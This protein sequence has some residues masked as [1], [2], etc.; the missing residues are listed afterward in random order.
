M[1]KLLL[2]IDFGTSTNFVTKY[3]FSKKDAVPVAN[4]G[5]YG[6]T[7]IFD[8]NIY[9]QSEDNYVIG[10][11]KKQHSDPENF[12]E[13]VKRYI[14]DDKKR[15]RVPN[16]NNR[17]VSAQDIAEMV[18]K[19]IAKK[20]EEN[21]N[22][23]IDGVVITVPYSYGKKY[24]QR[25]Q[26][27]ATNAGLKVIRLIEEPVAAAISYGIFGDDIKEDK[28]EKIAVFDLGGGTFDITI[29]D[30]E[31]SDAQH[32][33]IE[34]LNTDGVENLGGKTVDEL[35][36]KKFM[37]HLKIDYSIFSK[38]KERIKFQSELNKTAKNTK[39]LL[40]ESDE[41]EIYENVSINGE[42]K[43]LELNVSV[44]GFNGWLKDNNI[45]GKIEDAL[46]RAVY[47]IDLEPEDIDRVVLAGGT[48][49]IPII[50]STVEA[51]FGRKSEAKKDLGELVGHGA[52]I[53]AGL[54]EDS[55]LKYT[56]I[57]K[58]SKNIGVA[59]GNK[60]KKIL[61]KN[62]KYGEESAL[63]GQKLMN[64]EASSLNV[65]FYEGDSAKIE[66]SEKIGV[67]KINGKEFSSEQIYI[68]L[69]REDKRDSKI[70]AFFYNKDKDRVF[71]GYLE[72]V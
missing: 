48:S 35:L 47:D 14:V 72:D 71:E 8:N 59:R 49:T 24:R 57:R 39:E 1:D 55:S 64:R 31:K 20:V 62:T 30:F 21:E 10:D 34:V 15:Y 65:T 58:T 23:K 50:K 68:S 60:F 52:G 63:M 13:D 46:E 16:L 51:F 7:N 3:D 5:G 41:E 29:F 54:S 36:S 45:L 53:L 67:V 40:S 37:D 44:D 38:D 12:F 69:I 6:G 4:M 33:K 70:K 2:G 26:E 25:L 27:A 11:S 19:S 66:D 9:I 17:A 22:K 43:E 18:F 42:S 61:H 28:K 32:A 56:V